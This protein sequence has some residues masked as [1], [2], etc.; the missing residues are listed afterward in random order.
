VSYFTA[1]SFSR[2]A[3]LSGLFVLNYE[4]LVVGEDTVCLVT[5]MRRQEKKKR[6][7]NGVA[8]AQEEKVEKDEKNNYFAEGIVM[9]QRLNRETEIGI[10]SK[11][12]Y[13]RFETR[14]QQAKAWMNG[15]LTNLQQS[16]Y[17]IG[18]YGAD[19]S[20]LVLLNYLH[21]NK[22]KHRFSTWQLS[23]V[24]SQSHQMFQNMFTPGTN[25][26]LIVS[27]ASLF[28]ILFFCLL[29]FLFLILDDIIFIYMRR[30]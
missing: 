10:N 15:Q 8:E 18:G 4:V 12:F 3:E 14:S 24:L 29:F 27:K 2:A 22:T 13:E 25:V 1:H 21:G 6:K 11:L 16:G 28:L 9:K 7:K 30:H 19:P 5:M 23:W 17:S 20:N 26:P